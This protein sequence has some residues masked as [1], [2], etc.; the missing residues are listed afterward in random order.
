MYPVN[1][2]YVITK[3]ELGGA[4][5]Q[6]LSLIRHL[7]KTRFRPFL[8]TAREGVLTGEASCVSGLTLKKS[9][10]LERP[11]NPFL[12][13]LALI[14]LCL[15][16]KKNNIGILHT[17][18]S[19]AG[20]LGR[21]AA[22]LTGVKIVVHT[23]HGWSFNDYQACWRRGFFVWL[24][25]LAAGFSTKII[26][27]S[28]YDRDHGLINGISSP[29][30]YIIIRYGIDQAEFSASAQGLRSALGIRS[31]D[32]V[33]GMVACLK[34]Q[35][36]PQDFVRLASLIAASASGVKFL[37]AG[38]GVLRKQLLKLI[39]KLH[40]ENKIVLL[41]WRRDIP[42]VLSLLDVFVLTSLWE[43]LPISVLEAMASSKA[44]VATDTGGIREVILERDTGFLV[45]RSDVGRM[46]QRVNLLLESAELRISLGRRARKS[47]GADFSIETMVKSTEGLYAVLMEKGKTHA[48]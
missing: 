8:F 22:R 12:D 24:E 6:L 4:Q 26:V 45:G 9:R 13:F 33:V 37:L 35:K 16:I 38:D 41:G 48:Y 17:H 34:K 14:E 11:I 23:V 20:I 2:L 10:C 39:K 46:A 1:I 18:S 43:G 32:L 40:L 21:L 15:F 30:K 31:S 44:I 7:D 29:D 25:R 27:V 28:R 42:E 3:L 19:K 5:T 36:S 47:L